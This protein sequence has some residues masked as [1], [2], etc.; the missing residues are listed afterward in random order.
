[1]KLIFAIIN[2]DD[3]NEVQDA[4]SKEGFFATKFATTGSFL[5]KGNSTLIIG[6]EKEKV[7][8]VLDI[9]NK[10]SKKRVEPHPVATAYGLGVTATPSVDVTVGGATIFVTDIE[11]FEKY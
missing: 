4:L 1:M 8:N 11:R 7:D 3:C 6:V 5:G 2:R 10:N 9:I